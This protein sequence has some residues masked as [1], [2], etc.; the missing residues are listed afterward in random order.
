MTELKH[1]KYVGPRKDLQ[2]ETA[3]LQNDC[4]IS[5]HETPDII[6]AQFDD[7]D[8]FGHNTDERLAYGWHNFSETDFQIDGEDKVSLPFPVLFFITALA[9]A[10]YILFS[11]IFG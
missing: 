10:I 6:M 4:C 11:G 2:G 8:K 3:L 1:G 5:G 9:S 7:I